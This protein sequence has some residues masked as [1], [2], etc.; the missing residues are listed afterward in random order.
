M[1]EPTPKSP[2]DPPDA[3]ITRKQLQAKFKDY[4]NP[5]VYQEVIEYGKKKDARNFVVQFGGEES[6]IAL[7][8]DEQYFSTLMEQDNATRDDNKPIRW[9]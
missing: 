6:Q 9:M 1:S 7:D 5:D 4:D 3:K 8:L 2:V